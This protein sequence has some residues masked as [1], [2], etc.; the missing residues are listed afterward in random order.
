MCARGCRL[1][2]LVYVQSAMHSRLLVIIGL[3]AAKSDSESCS[4]SLRD[5]QQQ[6]RS[7]YL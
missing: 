5:G 2:V 6:Q 1:I 4:V 3:L 7:Y